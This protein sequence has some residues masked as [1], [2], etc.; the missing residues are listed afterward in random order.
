M[1]SCCVQAQH[2]HPNPEAEEA[3]SV[4]VRWWGAAGSIRW[5]SGGDDNGCGGGG[6]APGTAGQGQEV[7]HP[8]AQTCWACHHS[9]PCP[10]G[11]CQAAAIDPSPP[12]MQLRP[13]SLNPPSEPRASAADQQRRRLCCPSSP[14]LVYSYG[15]PAWQLLPELHRTPGD[16]VIDSKRTYDAFQ[17]SS[18]HNAMPTPPRQG[19]CIFIDATP[20][21][22]KYARPAVGHLRGMMWIPR[23]ALL[24]PDAAATCLAA[25]QGTE[26][27]SLLTE[28][29][30]NTLI[31]G[32]VMTNLCCET[33]A[34]CVSGGGPAAGRQGGGLKLH[35]F[36]QQGSTQLPHDLQQGRPS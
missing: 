35:P 21:G 29:G 25:V 30:C 31:V 10:R 32:G 8:G 24:L 11:T 14:P 15:S 1:P 12:A 16:K 2:G 22:T 36:L 18:A 9:G 3:S 26:L 7:T 33:T 34:R 27:L 6:G 19:C 5:V 20:S 17:A 13:A 28:R 4:L 23:L